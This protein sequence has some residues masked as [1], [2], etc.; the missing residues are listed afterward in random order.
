MSDIIQDK[1]MPTD[2]TS[3]P[4]VRS[5]E[6]ETAPSLVKPVPWL[7][8]QFFSDQNSLA[9]ELVARFP[10]PPLMSVIRIRQQNGRRGV[11]SMTTADN[12]ASLMVN[13]DGASGVT[14]FA[15]TY[16]SATGM[17]FSLNELSDMD[18][19]RWLELMRHEETG[20]AFLWGQKRWGN[21]YIICVTKRQF[22]NLYAFSHSGFEAAARLTPEVCKGLLDWLQGLW[23][24]EAA[25]L[26]DTQPRLDTW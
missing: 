5:A 25:Q 10:N 13:A 3:K 11:A 23:G 16:A 21:D 15:F 2:I 8:Q 7:I 4:S 12:V 26:D 19:A 18:R 22:A 24:V 17:R 6:M 20:A 1:P 9:G 14:E